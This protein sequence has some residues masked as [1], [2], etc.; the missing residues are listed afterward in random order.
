MAANPAMLIQIVA[1]AQKAKEVIKDTGQT[2]VATTSQMKRMSEGLSGDKIIRDALLMTQSIQGMGGALKLTETAQARVNA[3]VTEAIEQYRVLGKE[4][5]KEMLDLEAATRKVEQATDGLAVPAD[6]AGLSFGGLFGKVSSFLGPLGIGLGAGALVSFGKSLINAGGEIAD[7]SAKLGISAEATQRLKY[8][9]E[10]T[11]GSIDTIGVA[12]SKMN[13]NLGGGSTGTVAAL[14][15]VGLS[16][17]QIRAMQ[18]E[19]AF[20][21]IAEAIRA[22][23]TPALQADAAVKLLGKSGQDLLP[24]IKAGLIDIGKEAPVMSNATVAALDRAGDA[25]GRVGTAAKVWSGTIVASMIDIVDEARRPE[26]LAVMDV[27]WRKAAGMSTNGPE[28]QLGSQLT[29]NMKMM[30]QEQIIIAER[31]GQA[32]D[33]KGFA[34]M[35]LLQRSAVND[36][37]ASLHASKAPTE[38]YVVELKKATAEATKLTVE[39]RRQIDAGVALKKSTTD[40]A[41]ATGVS[42]AAI[43]I[44]RKRTD[45]ATDAT[46]KRAAEL[47]KAM[48]IEKGSISAAFAGAASGARALEQYSAAAMKAVPPIIKLEE[49][50][51]LIFS[52]TLNTVAQIE[53]SNKSIRDA[54]IASRD[55]ENAMS[56]TAAAAMQLSSVS[57][58]AFSTI[59]GG[60]SS[61]LSAALAMKSSIQQV[62]GAFTSMSSAGKMS[63]S[64]LM[65]ATTGFMGIFSSLLS[66]LP[67]DSPEV[68]LQTSLLEQISAFGG[69]ANRNDYYSVLGKVGM[70]GILGKPGTGKQGTIEANGYL[71]ALLETLM[72]NPSEFAKLYVQ[73]VQHHI[74][75]GMVSGH[76]VRNPNEG[77]WY[78]EDQTIEYFQFLLRQ[79]HVPGFVSGTGGRLVD[80]GP[81]TLA[82]LHGRERVQTEREVAK[83]RPA[84]GGKTEVHVHIAG[85]HLRTI[86]QEMFNAGQVLVPESAIVARAR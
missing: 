37:I 42:S 19:Q 75:T 70:S 27:F 21:A 17:N 24:A 20:N 33:A 67:G 6:T 16:L 50:H 22:L 64:S 9:A 72:P 31:M 43:E 36:Y 34:D 49:S 7:M 14:D 38:D 30:L 68:K 82:M 8:A 18:P 54:A 81:G 46:K 79:N 77:G 73:M 53:R 13:A 85:R 2:I 10:Q 52:N 71:Q 23:P 12:I 69:S 3:K 25:W 57:G 5:P 35:Y 58:G 29:A 62:Q 61:G 55:W 28:A 86:V 66:L 51:K 60:F 4:A 45:D 65:S 39:Q 11:G 48:Q 41:E 15:S 32:F 83:E 26:G 47:Q 44:Y 76:Q 59:L 40:I 56:G 80:F 78:S 1:N 74:P 63:F 84:G